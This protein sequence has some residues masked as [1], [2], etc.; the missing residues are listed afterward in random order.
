LGWVKDAA[1]INDIA[2]IGV[3]LL[4]FFI[5]LQL[6]PIELRR[7]VRQVIFLTL[8]ETGL[9]FIFG[10]GA[11]FLIGLTPIQS[12]IFAMVMSISS[13]AIVGKVFL[14][15][16]MFGISESRIIVGLMIMEDLIAVV[17]L[18]ALSS[19]T[20]NIN[21]SL[22]DQIIAISETILGGFALLGSA[23]IVATYLAPKAI[24]YLSPYELEF[25]EIPLLFALGLGFSFGVLGAVFGYS[26]AI[27]AFV[28]GLSIRGKQSQFLSK[29]VGTIKDLFLV[30]F[31]VS[32]GS[33][34]NP[35]PALAT[36]LPIVIIPLLAIAGK[37]LGGFIVGRVVLHNQK[38][39]AVK[40]QLFGAWLIP[41]GEFSFVIG[42]FA[43]VLGLIGNDLFSLIGL[44]VLITAIVGSLLQRLTEP[45]AAVSL[46]PY[47]AEKD[48][49]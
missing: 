33:M 48:K 40:P 1:T 38:T 25:E 13:T 28:I 46:H 22:T 24:N 41:R 30:L 18:I 7:M 17:F 21:T 34:I 35:F 15:R 5:G 2:T 45:K 39:G 3:V 20:I 11:S 37:F 26:P 36:G 4:L 6:D 16:K 19:I 23:Y 44:T 32:M 47:R 8:I 10:L 49:D 42:Q 27:G 31:F 14:E 43:L 29:E 12:I 9:A